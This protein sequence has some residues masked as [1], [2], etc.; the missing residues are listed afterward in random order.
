MIRCLVQNWTFLHMKAKCTFLCWTR[1]IHYPKIQSFG[2]D[3]HNDPK[4]L[5]RYAWANSAD[6]DQTAPIRVY[7]V[8]HSV[9]I[10]WTHYSMVEP[11]SSNFRVITTNILGVRMFRKSFS[12]SEHEQTVQTQRSSLISVYTACHS[13]FNFWMHYLPSLI[14]SVPI[15]M[16]FTES[17]KH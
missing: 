8:C 7:T 13:V 16:N 17:T 11:H 14:L 9:C 1:F 4:F 6:P 15:F 12:R 2:T 5:D 10:I 3:T